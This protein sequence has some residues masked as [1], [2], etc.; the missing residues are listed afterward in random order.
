M[1]ADFGLLLAD[2]SRSR[3]YMAALE[4][5][6]LR[7]SWVMLLDDDSQATMPG[8]FVGQ[9]AQYERAPDPRWP[10]AHFDPKAPLR[11]WLDR[12]GWP[13]ICT[14]SR[15]I[16]N[17]QV[18][19]AIDLGAPQVLV[20]SGYGGA[21]L[22]AP[23]LQTGRSFLH[24]H[25]GYLP[26][27]KGSTTNYYS[28]LADNSFG[29]SAILLTADIDGGPIIQRHRLPPPPVREQIDHVFDSAARAQVLV[30]VL[31]DW[32][33]TGTWHFESVDNKGGNTYYVIHPVLK[34]LA[35]LGAP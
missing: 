2:T 16:N 33:R 6:A 21:L 20:Y 24:V 31:K 32:Q 10:E 26:D 35:I 12:L 1:A 29:A 17:P 8:Q 18:V 4:R 15:D 14:N 5:H 34:H 27:F 22:R 23:V 28:L 25:G 3:A 19:E 9:T 30:S 13:T 11:P 7:P